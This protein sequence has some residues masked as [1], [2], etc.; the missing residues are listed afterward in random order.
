MEQLPLAAATSR[1]PWTP[2]ERFA[3]RAVFAY[4]GMFGLASLLDTGPFPRAILATLDEPIVGWYAMFT[5][6]GKSIGAFL[7]FFRRTTTLGALILIAV[8]SNVA[9]LNYVFDVP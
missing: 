4:F 1:A 8:L 6:F 3:F 5:G 7:L 9:L 2:A